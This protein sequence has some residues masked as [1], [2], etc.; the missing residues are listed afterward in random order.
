MGILDDDTLKVLRDGRVIG[1]MHRLSQGN[2]QRTAEAAKRGVRLE[3][4]VKD[5][6]GAER[7]QQVILK[8]V[9]G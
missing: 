3:V 6:H 5:K 8:K 9:R 2:P 4:R 1:M 7:T